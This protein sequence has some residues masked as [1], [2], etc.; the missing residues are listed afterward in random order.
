V[1]FPQFGSEL[2]VAPRNHFTSDE[3]RKLAELV[4]EHGETQWPMVV[5]ALPPRTP[6]QCKERWTRYLAP[7]VIQG[8]WRRDEDL[9]LI[10]K[11]KQHGQQWKQ[12]E[13]FFPGRKDHLKN[14]YRL[15][16][17]RGRKTP[18]L[19]SDCHLTIENEEDRFIFDGD[20]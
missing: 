1:V 14:D 5:S 3:D 19:S 11:V 17:R 7:N 12:L 16:L 9:V 4:V 2:N 20:V 15:L 8:H 18:I 6:R 10:E 13:A